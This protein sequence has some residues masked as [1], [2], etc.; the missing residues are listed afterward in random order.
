MPDS[1]STL[2]KVRGSNLHADWTPHIRDSQIQK[3]TWIYF[4]GLSGVVGNKA[5]NKLAGEAVI[6]D[7]INLLDPHSF[8]NLVTSALDNN[9]LPSSSHARQCVK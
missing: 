3:I 1:L 4:P 9:P 7:H 2:E 6:S 8:I 5:A